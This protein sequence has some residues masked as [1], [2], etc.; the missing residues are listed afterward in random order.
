MV[1][2]SPPIHSPPSVTAYPPQGQHQVRLEAG[3]QRRYAPTWHYIDQ[4]FEELT[5]QLEVEEKIKAGAEN[6]LKV[7]T[8]GYQQAER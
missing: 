6:L 7:S 3:E 4:Q 8:W 5:Q 2:G 1:R